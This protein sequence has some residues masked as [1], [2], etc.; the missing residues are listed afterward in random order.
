MTLQYEQNCSIMRF[1]ALFSGKWVL[2]IVYH[3]IEAKHPVRF[4]QLQKALA[5]IPQKRAIETF[6]IA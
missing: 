4:S 3:L 5:P 6:K 2:P 1:V